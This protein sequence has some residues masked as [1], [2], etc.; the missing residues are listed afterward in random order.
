MQVRFL[1]VSRLIWQSMRATGRV[2]LK[3]EI[4]TRFT[5]PVLNSA[6]PFSHRRD[7]RHTAVGSACRK[8]GAFRGQVRSVCDIGHIAHRNARPSTEISSACRG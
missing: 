4:S 2:L 7:T 6:V 1:H 3:V 8:P 5:L